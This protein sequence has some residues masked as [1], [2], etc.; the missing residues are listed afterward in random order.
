MNSYRMDGLYGQYVVILPDKNAIITYISSEPQNMT[1]VLELTWDT[2]I[3][4]L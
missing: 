4:K 2:L 3:D 1:E